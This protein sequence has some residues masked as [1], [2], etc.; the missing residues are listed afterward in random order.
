M[1]VQNVWTVLV[2]KK[3]KK[4]KGNMKLNYYPLLWFVRIMIPH[5]T[6][7]RF[8]CAKPAKISQITTER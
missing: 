7:G 4:T 2:K 6:A 1:A 5:D 8:T 3:K